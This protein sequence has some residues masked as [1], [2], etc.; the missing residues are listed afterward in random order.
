[1]RVL[2]LSQLFYPHVGGI[3]R[4]LL[5]LSKLLLG[6]G[7]KISIVTGRYKKSSKLEEKVFGV[8][9]FRMFYPRIKYFG[10]V[11]IWLGLLKYTDVIRQA[12]IIHIHD[13]FIWFLPYK[14]LFPKK[15]VYIT[16]HGY[17]SFP[18]KLN[19]ILLRKLAEF[20]CTGSLCVGNFMS[21]WYG[22]CPSLITYGAVDTTEFKVLD[23][24][25]YHYDAIFSSRLDKQTGI[26]V[27]AQAVS[28]LIKKKNKFRLLVL[29]DGP[30]KKKI[31]NICDTKG[32]VCDPSIYFNESKYAFV[33]RYLAIFEAFACKKLVFAV[34]DNPLKED[35]LRM[36]PFANWI[37]ISA[38]SKDLVRKVEYFLRNP[39]R[40]RK[41]IE[42]AYAWSKHK[43]WK[44]M[45]DIY[46]QLWEENQ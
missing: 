8:D 19:S 39:E 27:Y 15:R 26:S 25:K 33:S 40:A 23:R 1:M 28:G 42:N 6:R 24:K 35:Y 18:V 12:D 16:F 3:E 43:T 36:T 7:Y 37:N 30:Y 20:F 9:V 5:E 32:F 31:K 11:Y 10:L 34:C 17:E 13:V 14:F 44:E 2:M 4:H 41:M 29:G 22:T 38:D 45:S 46:I 21:K